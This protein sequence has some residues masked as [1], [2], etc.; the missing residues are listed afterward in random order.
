MS[1]KKNTL[2]GGTLLLVS[3]V[4]V[5]FLN[6]AFNAYLGRVLTFEDFALITLF[7]SFSYLLSVLQ[8]ALSV[9]MNHKSSALVGQ[10]GLQSGLEFRHAMLKRIIISS[11]LL[12]IA[13]VALIPITQSFFHVTMILPLL[14]TPIVM[15]SFLL[16]A[17]G[18][19]LQGTFH[20]KALSTVVVLESLSKLVI[21]WLFVQ[22]NIG[23]WAYVSI[24]LSTIVAFTL[25]MLLI[26]KPKE[27]IDRSKTYTFPRKFFIGSVIAGFASMAYLTFDVMLAK[28]FLTSLQAGQ[29]ALLSLI[30]KMIY[31]FALLPNLFTVAIVSRSGESARNKTFMIVTAITTGL[32][33]CAYIG[34]GLF[35]DIVIPILFGS[36]AISILPFL[37]MYAAAIAFFALSSCITTFHLA[38][39]EY[40]YP[41]SSIIIACFMCLALGFFHA[42]IEQFI[43]VILYTS[44]VSLAVSAG[45]H[46]LEANHV[47]SFKK[48]LSG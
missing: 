9:T 14:F 20:F 32:L 11:G 44:I 29:Y 36:K 12:S 28:H 46:I 5:N 17:N 4:V 2:S 24:T 39:Q 27:V 33:I 43:H 16:Y 40:A 10:Y 31:F 19:F 30:G 38:L 18:G 45:M 41:I 23:S 37:S 8:N 22:G 1:T 26:P 35:G 6:F 34:L 7:N 47:L 21:A 15:V 42:D 25:S 48:G 3:T 13:W